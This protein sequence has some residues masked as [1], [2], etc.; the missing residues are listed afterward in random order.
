MRLRYLSEAYYHGSPETQKIRGGFTQRFSYADI[1]SDPM[2][3]KKIIKALAIIDRDDPR[4]RDLLNKAAELHK[5]IKVPSGIFL[6]PDYSVAATYA[7]EHRAWDY[8]NAVGGVVEVEVKDAPTVSI[9]GDGSSFRGIKVNLVFLA[10]EEF[11]FHKKDIEDAYYSMI[12]SRREG[13]ISTDD[14]VE[15]AGILGKIKI[16]DIHNIRDNYIGSGKVTTVR[17]VLDASL[18]HII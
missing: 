13:I 7:D 10:L 15:L 6:T 5:V 8:Q 1:S 3:S 12:T 14:L 17:I 4:K 16:I 2:L 9:H 11:G 18:L